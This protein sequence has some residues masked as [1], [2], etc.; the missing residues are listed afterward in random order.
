MEQ[1][2]QTTHVARTG[3]DV[4]LPGAPAAAVEDGRQVK[5]VALLASDYIGLRPKFHVKEGDVVAR[6]QLLFEDR[7][8]EGA[9]FTSP[10]SGRV[11]AIHRGEKRA[12]Q[13][14]VIAL[15]D[16]ELSG[17][18]APQAPMGSLS[19][20]NPAQLSAEEV[21]A[22]LVESGLWTALRARPFGRV[23]APMGPKPRAVFVTAMSTD[24]GRPDFALVLRDREQFLK[25]GLAALVQLVGAGR[26]HF[27]RATGQPLPGEQVSGV[28]VHEF[29]GPHPAGTVGFHIHTVDPVG[30]ER[31]HYYLG[32][33]DAADM[34]EL[35]LSGR[36]PISR[37]V[38]LGGPGAVRPRHLRTRIGASLD[39][40]LEEELSPGSQ[41]VLSGSVLSGREARGEIHGYLGR[42]HNQI[43]ALSDDA[44]RR[45]LGWLEPG[46]RRF[47]HTR[48]FLSALLRPRD[49]AFSTELHGGKR[50]LV[51]TGAYE[52]VMPFEMMP[53]FLLRAI[54]AGDVET[55][56]ELGVLELE[57]E[58]LALCS[59]VCPSKIEYG[60]ALRDMLTRIEKEG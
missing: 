29:Q 48:L 1:N 56:E 43:A 16:D 26:V 5:S 59:L 49:L 52:R 35:L 60:P 42:Y 6:A 58:D 15:D 4:P 47:S 9:R 14:L 30:P 46:S 38:G 12:F 25:A 10:A 18:D 36:L 11:A 40:L 33:Q 21:R 31:M 32:A 44:P 23:P 3:L 19:R 7:K 53:N 57:E 13:S 41:R 39:A 34:G 2:S 27:C 54:L 28:V 22:A 37:V 51:P 24:P 45:F 17:Q 55:A 20:K 50:A 8:V